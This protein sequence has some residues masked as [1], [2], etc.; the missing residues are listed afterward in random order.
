MIQLIH[1]WLVGSE[2]ESVPALHKLSF[3]LV[4]HFDRGGKIRSKMKLVM[5]EVEHFSRLEGVWLEGRWTAP[6][7]TKMWSTIWLYL[8][9]YLRTLTRKKDDKE[10]NKHSRR[11]QIAWQTFFNKLREN[12]K[13]MM[14]SKIVTAPDMSGEASV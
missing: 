10:S 12:G 7:V 8:K 9:P 13:D 11:G 6:A 1:L 14:P 2:K 3:S 4:G 5:R